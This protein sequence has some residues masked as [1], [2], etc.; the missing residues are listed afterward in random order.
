MLE[1]G[2]HTRLITTTR[3]D[4]DIDTRSLDASARLSGAREPVIGPALIL[5]RWQWRQSWRLM[6]IAGA[7]M[8]VAVMLVCAVPL[9]SRVMLTDGLRNALA[10]SPDQSEIIV[11]AFTDAPTGAVA[12]R[13]TSAVTQ[14]IDSGFGSYVTSAIASRVTTQ[15]LPLA[16]GNGRSGVASA[17]IRLEGYDPSQIQNYLDVRLGQFPQAG[18]GLQVIIS[19]QTADALRLG[20]G[21]TIVITGKPDL[22][23][24]VSGII[25]S[26]SPDRALPQW[27][28]TNI[29]PLPNGAVTLY[30]AIASSGA[31]IAALSQHTADGLASTTHL[32]WYAGVNPLSVTIDDLDHLKAQAA[33]IPT[34][35]PGL[36]SNDPA[37]QA[38]DVHGGFFTAIGQFA[39][40]A[41]VVRLPV[42]LLTVQIVAL[43]LFFVAVIAELLVER[44][45]E[46]LA[47]LRS[48]G[49]TRAQ[50]V[51][52]LIAESAA[53]GIVATAL[54]PVL[55]IFLARLVASIEIGQDQMAVSLLD[56]H[57][58]A[59]ALSVG[60]YALIAGLGAV[61]AMVIATPRAAA[62]HGPH[63]ARP[64]LAAPQSGCRGGAH[65]ADGLRHSR[66]QPGGGQRTGSINIG[67]GVAHRAA[68]PA[69]RG[70]PAG[71]AASAAATARGGRTGRA[72]SRPRGDAGAL[73]ACA[74]AEPRVAL[75]SLAGAGGRLRRFRARL[76][77]QPESARQRCGGVCR[78]G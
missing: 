46:P 21:S 59:N 42:T 55:A 7:G 57:L 24:Q 38:P 30:K 41:D 72:R 69:R 16:E 11:D 29:D 17:Q 44:Q 6:S 76:W 43:V 68:L 28:D 47:V 40:R 4:L 60:G 26:A 74:G 12:D 14:R 65:R 53:L 15:D 75:G 73:A 63:G 31:L 71:S 5:A 61:V 49:A 10:S 66:A 58:S 45:A 39:G 27:I 78:G 2:A 19:Q 13:A 25:A 34:Q 54:G 56:A 22:R 8:L 37:I 50:V 51:A 77:R 67:P 9:L 23:A 70:R 32:S 48:R 20:V 36:L 18:A 3:G 64:A 1:W 62:R 35:M 33:S 52:A